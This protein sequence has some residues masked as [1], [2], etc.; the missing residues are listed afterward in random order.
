MGRYKNEDLRLTDPFF[1]RLTAA[2]ESVLG[3]QKRSIKTMYTITITK[4]LIDECRTDK[5]SFTNETARQLGAPFPLMQG[6]PERLIG[7]HISGAA[8]A[9]AKQARFVKH[10]PWFNRSAGQLP[11]F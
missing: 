11:L 2:E 5:G 1:R 9:A 3:I 7:K 8:F 4:E 10:E 6:W